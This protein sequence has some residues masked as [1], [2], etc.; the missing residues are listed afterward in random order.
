MLPMGTFRGHHVKFVVLDLTV[1]SWGI[2]VTYNVT[3]TMLDFL[4][5]FFRNGFQM[6]EN[7]DLLKEALGVL[8]QRIKTAGHSQMSLKDLVKYVFIN[9]F[10]ILNMQYCISNYVFICCMIKYISNKL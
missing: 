1:E 8:V 9:S 10:A 3:L 5:T 6:V 7:R 2:N 4:S